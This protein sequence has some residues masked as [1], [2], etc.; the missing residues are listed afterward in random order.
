MMNEVPGTSKGGV[1]MSEHKGERRTDAWPWEQALIDDYYDYRCHQV[2]EPLCETFRRWKAGEL[3]HADVDRAI[4]RAYQQR[5]TMHNLFDQR[6]DR[7]V[8][9]IRLWDPEWF[10]AWVEK[11]RPPREQVMAAS[12]S[13]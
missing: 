5:C 2:M 13:F 8:A 11:H 1:H 7:T 4:E 9:L 12:G 6:P 3:S 10:D